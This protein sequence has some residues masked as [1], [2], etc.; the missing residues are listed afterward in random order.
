[1]SKIRLLLAIWFPFSVYIFLSM[2]LFLVFISI[3]SNITLVKNYFVYGS[4]LSFILPLLTALGLTRSQQWRNKTQLSLAIVACQ[5]II[6]CANIFGPV[7]I[8]RS[9]SYHLVFYA[10]K[11]GKLDPKD[12]ERRLSGYVFSKRVEDAL[13]A[14]L[15][16]SRDGEVHPTDKAERFEWIFQTLGEMTGSLDNYQ[17]MI[18]ESEK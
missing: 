18:K 2:A 16:E 1:M 6:F 10:V 7:F 12:F 3:Y 15:L 5:L 14:G 17:E 8:D 4:I 9:I 11:H 13:F